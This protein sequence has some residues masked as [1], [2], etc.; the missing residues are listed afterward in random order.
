MTTTNAFRQPSGAAEGLT[1]LVWSQKFQVTTSD[2]TAAAAN[3][4]VSSGVDLVSTIPGAVAI[5]PVCVQEHLGEVFAGGSAASATVSVGENGG[6]V[7]GL[8][9]AAS[10]FTGVTLGALDAVLRGAQCLGQFSSYTPGA[11]VIITSD[12][13]DN[14]TTGIFSYRVGFLPVYDVDAYVPMSL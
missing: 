3:E 8:T 6:D 9:A 1:G 4:Q 11:N 5:I 13:V 2:L 7:D 14:L 10:V 12:N